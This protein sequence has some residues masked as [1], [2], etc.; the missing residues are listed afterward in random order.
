M[1]IQEL[2]KHEVD[3]CQSEL[4]RLTAQIPP[5]LSATA[6]N[7]NQLLLFKLKPNTKK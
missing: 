1:K 2:I 7:T 3:T 6:P 4:T 5:H